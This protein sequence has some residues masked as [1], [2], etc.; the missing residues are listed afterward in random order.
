[1]TGRLKA[2]F[3]KRS[4]RRQKQLDDEYTTMTPSEREVAEAGSQRG[5]AGGA[6]AYEQREAERNEDAWE[7]EGRP[8][9]EL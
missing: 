7:G 1:M 6:E 5:A 9:R 3:A 8:P 4:A 2:F